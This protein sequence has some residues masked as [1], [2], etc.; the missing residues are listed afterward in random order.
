MFQ[1]TRSSRQL[2]IAEGSQA[3]DNI[4]MPTDEET[5]GRL[6]EASS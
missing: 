4:K 3:Q 2:P 1:V 5:D 6:N